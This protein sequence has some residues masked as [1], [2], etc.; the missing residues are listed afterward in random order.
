MPW[1]I[2]DIILPI[3]PQGFKKKVIRF[4][5]PVA[6]LNDFPDPT[7]NQPTRFEL[8]IKGF[9]WPLTKAIALDELAKNAETE[10]IPISVTDDAGVEDGWLSGTYSTSRSSMNRERPLYFND[11]GT[12][13]EVYEYNFSFVKFADLGADQTS[14]EGG[15]GGDEDTGFFDLPDEIGFDE[16]GDGEIDASEIFNWL[17]NILTFGVVK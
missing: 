2:E 16:D 6:I 1:Q 8:T 15:P 11:N 7:L 14:E 17:V 4:Q 10:N 13:V 12:E 3:D 5:K 9:I